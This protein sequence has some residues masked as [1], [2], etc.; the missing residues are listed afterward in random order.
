MLAAPG[1]ASLISREEMRRA[2]ISSLCLPHRLNLGRPALL[3]RRV[4]DYYLSTVVWV[5]REGRAEK[6]TELSG[7]PRAHM[8]ALKKDSDTK[9]S[10]ENDQ[11]VGIDIGI[12]E[13]LWR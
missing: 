12:G 2:R 4:L 7:N 13:V 6:I 11:G 10:Q 8:D 9:V 5:H 3:G 1:H